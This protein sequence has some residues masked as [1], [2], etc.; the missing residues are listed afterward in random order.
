MIGPVFGDF[1]TNRSVPPQKSRS[2]NFGIRNK[3]SSIFYRKTKALISC[4]FNLADAKKPVFS[5]QMHIM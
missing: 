2:L 5:C 3:S 4:N 1:N